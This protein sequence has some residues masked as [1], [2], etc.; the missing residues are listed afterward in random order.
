MLDCTYQVVS[1]AVL[2]I[3]DKIAEM[4]NE[5]QSEARGQIYTGRIISEIKTY[6]EGVKVPNF[7]WV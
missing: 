4:E 6:P 5:V 3:Q 1:K 7:G 2:Y